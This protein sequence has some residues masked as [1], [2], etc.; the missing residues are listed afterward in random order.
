MEF[1]LKFV[2]ES[3]WGIAGEKGLTSLAT[4]TSNEFYAA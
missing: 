3:Q 1:Y 2:G 4:K